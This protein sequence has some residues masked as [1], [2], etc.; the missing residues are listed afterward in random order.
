MNNDQVAWGFNSLRSNDTYMPHWMV[1]SSNGL[2]PVTT[3]QYEATTWTNADI[4]SVEPLGTNFSDIWMSN[5]FTE[6]SMC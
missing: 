2:L 4:L 1:H 5:I 6:V 3:V